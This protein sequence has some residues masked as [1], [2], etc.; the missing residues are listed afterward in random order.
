MQSLST[1]EQMFSFALNNKGNIVCY[2][3]NHI[4]FT[5]AQNE[6]TISRKY[7]SLNSILFPIYYIKFKD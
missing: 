4:I 2:G 6:F 7:G 3:P 1:D 5:I